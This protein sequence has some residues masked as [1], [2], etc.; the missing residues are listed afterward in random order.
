MNVNKLLEQIRKLSSGSLVDE[1]PEGFRCARAWAKDWNLCISS[2]RTMLAR[3]TRDGLMEQKTFQVLTGPKV[4]ATRH[5]RPSAKQ[6]KL[7]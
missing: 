3:A 2:T 7:R 4:S 6:K 1:V 5:W